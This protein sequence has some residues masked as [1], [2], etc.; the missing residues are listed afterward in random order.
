MLFRIQHRTTYR[1][2]GEASESFMEA[3]LTPVEDNRQ[4]LLSR[5]FS[6]EPAGRVHRYP[7]YFGNL[8]ESFA[9]AHRHSRLVVES[10][11][12]V[13]THPWAPPKAALEIS[14]SEARQIYR[15]ER[16]RLYEFLMPSDAITMSAAVNRLAN[17]FFKSGNDLGASLLRLNHWIKENFRYVPGIT[18]IDTPVT[19]VLTL[20]AGVCQ[21]FA[22]VMIAILRSAEIPARYV[23]GYIET[24]NQ[25]K[26]A[27][28]KN[29]PAA[30]IGS[31]ESHA[32]VEVYLPG[33]F[34]YPLDPTNDCAVGE[35]HVKVA[36]GRDY[37]D[38]T[39]TRGVFKGTRTDKLDVSVHMLRQEAPA[40][41]KA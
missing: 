34:W 8:V 29:A 7:D 19:E 17:Q 31:A 37:H 30:L 6:T 21:D 2:A 22:Q 3:R 25:R 35:R 40:A 32:W 13:E 36:C 12:V 16:L 9:V 33:G 15:S 23:T 5:D 38:S 11:S 24:E 39:P 14:V 28:L 18:R 41:I 4:R 20:K 27:E 26:A 1:Y 10:R